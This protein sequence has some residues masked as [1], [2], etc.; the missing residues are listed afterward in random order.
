MVD[1]IWQKYKNKGRLLITCCPLTELLSGHMEHLWLHHRVGQHNGDCGGFAGNA[2]VLVTW[3]LWRGF[4][5]LEMIQGY[6]FNEKGISLSVPRWGCCCCPWLPIIIRLLLTSVNQHLQHELP[7][8][9]PNGPAHQAAEARLHHP[10]PS[11][12]LC[13]V[14]QGER[15]WLL[16]LSTV[17]QPR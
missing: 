7:E 13:A 9:V 5:C 6:R 14:I 17:K 2:E 10:H 1:D 15:C 16:L 12:D 3:K 4:R 11:L 8:A